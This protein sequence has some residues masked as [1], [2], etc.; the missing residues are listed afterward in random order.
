MLSLRTTLAVSAVYLVAELSRE[1]KSSGDSLFEPFFSTLVKLSAGTKKLLVAASEAAMSSLLTY[2]TCIAKM[3]HMLA[4]GMAEKSAVARTAISAQLPVLLRAHAR[5]DKATFDASGSTPIVE[6]SI[7]KALTDATPSVREKARDAYWVFYDVWPA[8]AERI[9]STLDTQGRIQLDKAKARA[10]GTSNASKPQLMKSTSSTS[11][12]P[13]MKEMIAARKAAAKKAAQDT[14]SS[15]ENAVEQG[16]IDFRSPPAKGSDPSISRLAASPQT[17]GTPTRKPASRPSASAND[18]SSVRRSVY[19]PRRSSL[20]RQSSS[21]SSTESHSRRLSPTSSPEHTPQKLPPSRRSIADKSV[22]LMAFATPA[23]DSSSST[24]TRR[25]SSQ[26]ADDS[27]LADRM[28]QHNLLDTSMDADSGM[29]LEAM[30][31]QANQAEQT[32]ERLL[33]LAADEEE[34]NNGEEDDDGPPTAK[35]PQTFAS[36]RAP[37]ASTSSALNNTP[38]VPATPFAKKGVSKEFQDSP[39]VEKPSGSMLLSSRATQ[40]SWWLEKAKCTCEV[41]L[42]PRSHTLTYR[43][44]RRLETRL[45]PVSRASR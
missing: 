5:Q 1:L 9:A 43:I 7:R 30:R 12:R 32:A 25:R 4:G 13:S 27:V 23:A 41:L 8:E 44:F 19:D 20:M 34:E 39:A 10:G 6:Q 36:P 18:S 3:C 42:E 33:E 14:A 35:L 2:S 37:A 31:N 28:A 29:A 22:N 21:T 16:N 26:S 24:G 40:D 38:A 17:P 15:S 45:S 11:A